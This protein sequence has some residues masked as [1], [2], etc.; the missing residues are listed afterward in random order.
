MAIVLVHE[1]P[2]FTEEQYVEIVRRMTGGKTR[3]ES[4]ADWPVEGLLVHVAGQGDNGFRV[5]DVWEDEDACRQFADKLKPIMDEVGVTEQA[6]LYPLHS[7][8]AA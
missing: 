7:F 8:V 6:K 4:L 3:M 2:T 5:V 1:G